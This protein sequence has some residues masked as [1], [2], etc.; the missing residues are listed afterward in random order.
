MWKN[1][2][3]TKRGN[4]CMTLKDPRINAGGVVCLIRIGGVVTECKCPPCLES[5]TEH[6]R[7]VMKS[8]E[9]LFI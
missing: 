2:K 3:Q 5:V 8:L 6:A 1:K 9:P 7:D 4:W